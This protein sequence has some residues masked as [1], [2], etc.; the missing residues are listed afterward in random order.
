MKGNFAGGLFIGLLSCVVISGCATY[1]DSLGK[2]KKKVAQE[3]YDSATAPIKKP[4]SPEGDDRLLYHLE[5]GTVKRLAGQYEESNKHF[6]TADR[7]A[8]DLQTK[9]VSQFLESMMTSP[10]SRPYG[11][12][13]FE[14]AYINYYKALNYL[15]MA[16]NAGS[17]DEQKD[18]MEKSRI[19]IRRVSNVLDAIAQQEGNYQNV[20]D[21]EKK[22]FTKLLDIFDKLRG[23]YL[24]EDMLEFRDDASARYLAGILY[25][26]LGE[27]DNA[28]IQYE[29]AAK[30]YEN[31]YAEQYDLGSSMTDQA[32]FDV[33]RIMEKVGGYGTRAPRLKSEKLSS[34]DRD[35][36]QRITQNSD[37]LGR[38]FVLKHIGF[39]AEPREMNL[40]VR[41]DA[42]QKAL[43]ISPVLT[44]T[45]AEQAAQQDWF[46][47]LYADTGLLDMAHAY[48]REGLSEVVDSLAEKTIP[49][50]PAWSTA[51]D[52]GIIEAINGAG[53]IRV[54]VPYYMPKSRSLDSVKVRV[55]GE[56]R[57]TLDRSD[58]LKT[59][60]VQEQLLESG[61]DLKMGLARAT[62][63][64]MGASEAGEAAGGQA[65]FFIEILGRIMGAASSQAETRSWLT[66]PAE[67]QVGSVALKPGKHTVSVHGFKDGREVVSTRREFEIGAGDVRVWNERLVSPEMR[68]SL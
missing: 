31:G 53:G 34:E 35:R 16:Q 62:L 8:S 21:N 55:D 9:R 44:G 26:K 51:V 17:E 2:A 57:R 32:W 64:N 66:L 30:L 22:L 68:Q 19:E 29:N 23:N 41:A 6:N 12:R 60:A 45:A 24:D 50:G 28:R 27:L 52:A 58:S 43:E 63:K 4:L 42:G 48:Y 67:A 49:L 56:T 13:D 11:G 15:D 47:M 54:T 33:V 25:E 65:G 46:T 38:L 18:Y 3:E 36:L 61:R 1:G 14:R 59:L 37:N 20:E 39:T 7:I 40:M 5:L 10:R